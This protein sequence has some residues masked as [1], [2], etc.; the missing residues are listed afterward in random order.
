VESTIVKGRSL[1]GFHS[2]A[3]FCVFHSFC[4]VCMYICRSIYIFYFSSLSNFSH[5]FLYL[6]TY[7]CAYIPVLSHLSTFYVFRSSISIFFLSPNL[8]FVVSLSVY[9]RGSFFLLFQHTIVRGSY[10]V[11]VIS[12]LIWIQALTFAH[13][14]ALLFISKI[15]MKIFLIDQPTYICRYVCTYVGMYVHMY[16]CMYICMYVCTYVCMYVCM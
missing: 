7:I 4:L 6:C 12:M 10:C 2:S 9:L 11:K 1:S 15:S 16:V 14:I 3:S 5:T 8:L 13:S